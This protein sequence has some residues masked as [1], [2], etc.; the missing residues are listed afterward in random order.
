LGPSDIHGIG[1]FAC[2]P[3]A[4]GTNVFSNDQREIRWVAAAI[5]DDPALS[6]FQRSLYRDFAIRRGDELG[7]PSNFILLTVGWYVN[8]PRP[9]DEANLTSTPEFDLIAIRYI[10]PGEELTL[11][12]ESFKSVDA[13]SSSNDGISSPPS[14]LSGA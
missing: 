9:G 13:T 7:C 10:E 3:I 1:V 2:E 4:P 12:Y 14:L 8:E 6:D 5:L 11:D